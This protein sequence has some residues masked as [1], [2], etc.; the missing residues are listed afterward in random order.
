MERFGRK[1][2]SVR[3]IVDYTKEHMACD[4]VFQEV[5]EYVK[6]MREYMSRAQWFLLPRVAQ[7]HFLSIGSF[8]YWVFLF[9]LKIPRCL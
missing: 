3:P 2:Q 1:I 4:S 9:L 7:A 5:R 8:Y 6:K